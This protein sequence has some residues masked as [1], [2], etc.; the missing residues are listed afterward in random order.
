MLAE[1]REL[2]AD[3]RWRVREGVAMALQ[4][5]GD[6]DPAALLDAMADWSTGSA[7][8]QRA[9]V[10]GLCE[11][12]LLVEAAHTR[13]VLRILDRITV[14]LAEAADR[15]AE[16]FR[17][18]R[19][20]LGY[21]W[22]VA[23]AALPEAGKASMEKWFASADRDVRWVMRENLKKNRLARIDAGWVAAWQARLTG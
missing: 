9:A 4:R 8:E 10:A 12:R 5:W 22:S 15:R 21:G 20:A 7:W 18:L 2:A 19:Q 6:S 23:A 3:P 17:V 16:S 1:L 14:A 11:P 13:A